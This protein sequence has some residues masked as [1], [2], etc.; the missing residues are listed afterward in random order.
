E[1]IVNRNNVVNHAK[2]GSLF[3]AEYAF[4]IIKSAIL[5]LKRPLKLLAFMWLLALVMGMAWFQLRKTISPFC[6]IPGLRHSTLCQPI[7]STKAKWADYD[8]LAQ[9]QS[10]SFGKILGETVGNSALSLEI[11]RAEMATAD[12]ATL[13]RVS[14][15]KAKKTLEGHLLDFNQ[16]AK[17]AGRGL[18]KLSSKIG[19][20]VDSIMAVND[21][22][23]SSIEQARAKEPTPWSFSALMNPTAKQR[24]KQVI[25]SSFDQAMGV[26]STHMQLLIVEAELNLK[27]LDDLEMALNVLHEVVAREESAIS[28]EKEEVLAQLWTKLG[29]NRRELRNFHQ[30]LALLQNL[31]EY[32]KQARVHV[33][34]TLQSLE[35]L[36]DD[37]EDMRER[38]AAPEL[39]GTDVPAEVHMKSIQMGLERMKEGRIKARE[40]EEAA[41][42]R[43]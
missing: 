43:L 31:G 1:S 40:L 11:K 3:V 35:A 8:R 4:D 7:T 6:G 9:V 14:D 21:H 33:V 12:L 5:M 37:M 20:A 13:V 18:Q 41:L 36:S 28:Q 24:T 19:G 42:N 32:R 34:A 26:L 27:K 30:N 23:M 2:D 10:T 22:A 17:K 39:M 29:G 16:H 38:V 25:T 15:L